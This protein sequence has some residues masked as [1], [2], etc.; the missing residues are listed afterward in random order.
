MGYPMTYK[1]VISRNMLTGGYN[2][3]IDD[4]RAFLRGDLRRL[5]EDQRDERHLAE[6]AK[7]TGV[8]RRKV[9]AVLDALFEGDF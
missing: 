7:R 5:E 6:Y 9:K 8:S 1:R 2:D 3:N 4:G